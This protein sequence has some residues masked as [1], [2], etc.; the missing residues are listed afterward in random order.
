MQVG[1][2]GSA[3]IF[4]AVPRVEPLELFG[5]LDD[6]G[7]P[8]ALIPKAGSGITKVA[9]FKSNRIAMRFNH[10]THVHT[11]VGWFGQDQSR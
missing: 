5:I 3:G 4:A 7:E 8:E 11:M 9:D 1:E 6:T 2:F 10:T